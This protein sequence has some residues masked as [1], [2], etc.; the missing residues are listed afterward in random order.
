MH[1]GMAVDAFGFCIR[2]YQGCMAGNAVRFRV[3]PREGHCCCVVIKGV[4]CLIQLPAAGAVADIAAYL[5]L[6]SMRG[7]W[8]K[9][10]REESKEREY[11]Q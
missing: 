3:V 8:G 11:D 7:I 4:D 10:N 2:K 5:E 9:C 1:I 6:V